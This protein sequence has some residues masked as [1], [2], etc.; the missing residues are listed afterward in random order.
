M[1]SQLSGSNQ[2]KSTSSGPT[3]CAPARR[4]TSET[5]QSGEKVRNWWTAPTQ[6]EPSP[7]AVATR[8]V[9][10]ERTSPTA[11]RPGWLVSNGSGS[12]PRAAQRSSRWSGPRARSVRTKPRSSNAAQPEIQSEDGLG[13]DEGEEPRAGDLRLPVGA[14]HLDRLQVGIPDQPG[15]LRLRPHGDARG[16]RQCDRSGSGTCSCRGRRR[17]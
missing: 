9:E 2:R 3:G 13:P 1:L 12:R 4:G 14:L 10:P 5:G 7:T 6:A 15:D 8:L 11:N 16:G 17:G